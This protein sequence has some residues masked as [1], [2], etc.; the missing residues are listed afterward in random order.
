[1]FPENEENEDYEDCDPYEDD[2][3]C[4]DAVD[5]Y[6]CVANDNADLDDDDD[7]YPGGDHSDW[8]RDLLR[9]KA[10]Y[11]PIYLVRVRWNEL[12][13]SVKA[14]ENAAWRRIER[15]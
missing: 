15:R 14:R 9:M 2:D 4:V 1:M 6:G 5:P 13:N 10:G 12:S 8:G 11:A 7:W 3:A